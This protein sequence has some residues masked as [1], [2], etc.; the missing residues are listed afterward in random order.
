VRLEPLHFADAAEEGQGATAQ[1]VADGGATGEGV[2]QG[3]FDDDGG[4]DA[5]AGRQ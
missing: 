4:V 1:K 2:A 3:V 5:K